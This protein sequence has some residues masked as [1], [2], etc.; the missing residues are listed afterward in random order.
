MRNHSAAILAAL[1]ALGSL[2][3]T[4]AQQHPEP[5][6]SAIRDSH[7][8]MTISVE[9][10]TRAG[11]Y[12]EKFPKKSPFSGGVVA[13]HVTFTNESDESIKVNLQSIRLVVL[14]EEDTRQELESLS[15]EDVA[16]TVMLSKGGKDPT[17]RRIPVPIPVGKPRA[18]RDKNW[19][20]FK[21]DCQNAAL[22]SPVVA[23]HSSMDG[24]VYFDLR[25]EWELLQTARLYVPN[26]M[27]M[28]SK[29]PLSYFDIDFAHAS[30]N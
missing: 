19:M 1:L 12:K 4:H 10:W 26:L 9:L 14:I 29:Q 11:Q 16:D 24:L 15:A 8:G 5:A 27:T 7:E 25:G 22:P 2:P 18:S 17:T 20:D 6:R 28:G 30:G 3:L 13:L 23:A 21:N